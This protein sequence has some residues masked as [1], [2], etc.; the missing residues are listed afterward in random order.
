MLFYTG[1]NFWETSIPTST[2]CHPPGFR[3]RS[4]SMLPN[5]Y[6]RTLASFV[7]PEREDLLSKLRSGINNGFSIGLSGREKMT[8]ADIA[9]LQARMDPDNATDVLSSAADD[10]SFGQGGNKSSLA[11]LMRLGNGI[12]FRASG[13]PIDP[14]KPY[15]V[16]ENEPEVLVSDRPGYVVPLKDL[17]S[18]S[19]GQPGYTQPFTSLSDLMVKGPHPNVPSPPSLQNMVAYTQGS[20]G[21]NPIRMDNKGVANF[22]KTPLSLSQVGEIDKQW[23]IKPLDQ[24]TAADKQTVATMPISIGATEGTYSNLADITKRALADHVDKVNAGLGPRGDSPQ[25]LAE[26]LRFRGGLSKTDASEN[27]AALRAEIA[28]EKM[29]ADYRRAIDL[30]N[31]RSLG[32]LT[33]IAARGADGGR[34]TSPAVK[35]ENRVQRQIEAYKRRMDAIWSK[36]G[37]SQAYRSY[38]RALQNIINQA[39]RNGIEWDNSSIGLDLVPTRPVGAPSNTPVSIDMQNTK[40]QAAIKAGYTPEEISAFLAKGKR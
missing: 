14:N 25:E 40:V 30:Q 26:F 13:G 16:G 37:D 29:D 38:R 12:E 31:A 1:G 10:I 32:T 15:I 4:M 39:D 6:R 33:A 28:R 20:S 36:E 22:D 17:G 9:N 19:G 8:L 3:Q 5:E 24:L 2:Q 21:F 23:G 7:R 35:A 27:N 34:G 18:P 11:A